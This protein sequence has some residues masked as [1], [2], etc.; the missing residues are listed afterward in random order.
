[1]DAILSGQ[2]YTIRPLIR[3]DRKHLENGL[4]ELSPKSRIRRFHSERD[5]FTER[6][7]DYLVSCDGVNHLAWVAGIDDGLPQARGI[8]VARI[9]RDPTE[10]ESGE[11]AVTVADDWQGCGVGSAL[12][13]HLALQ[14]RAI[15]IHRWVATILPDNEHALRLVS[16]F[17]AV[18]S[19]RWEDGGLT[20]LLDLTYTQASQSC[21]QP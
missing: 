11:V 3:N 13:M 10:P 8:G 19:R 5:R 20:L 14:S 4:R 6:E 21:S 2:P 1:M 17:G 7:L 16:K 9:V 18:V 12:L 15:G